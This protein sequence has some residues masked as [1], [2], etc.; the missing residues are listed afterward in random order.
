MKGVLPAGNMD[1]PPYNKCNPHPGTEVFLYPSPYA[2]TLMCTRLVMDL[3][4]ME[5]VDVRFRGTDAPGLGKLY[6]VL[7]C[8]YTTCRMVPGVTPAA[9]IP[10]GLVLYVVVPSEKG[11]EATLLGVPGVNAEMV[12]SAILNLGYFYCGKNTWSSRRDNVCYAQGF[13]GPTAIIYPM[14]YLI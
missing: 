1:S 10:L 11:I 5:N 7:S 2:D 3:R 12:T 9:T 4:F 13:S 6:V 14:L 8:K